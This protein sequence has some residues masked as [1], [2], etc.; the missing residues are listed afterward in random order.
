[1]KKIP[2]RRVVKSMAI[3]EGSEEPYCRRSPLRSRKECARVCWV[4]LQ[5]NQRFKGS[6][7]KHVLVTINKR[8]FLDNHCSWC[9]ACSNVQLSELWGTEAQRSEMELLLEVTFQLMQHHPLEVPFNL[10]NVSPNTDYICQAPLQLCTAMSL[11]AGQRNVEQLPRNL[12]KI[13]LVPYTCPLFLDFFLATW[14]V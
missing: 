10:T 13:L 9:W 4:I 2:N 14:N 7:C 11:H 5:G 3:Q 6:Q 12:C 1:M 8:C